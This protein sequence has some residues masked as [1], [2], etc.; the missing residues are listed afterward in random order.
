LGC[1]GQ[2]SDT[3][4]QQDQQQQQHQQQQQQ[5]EEE[6][7]GDTLAAALSAQELLNLLQHVIQGEQCADAQLSEAF[8]A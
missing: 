5:E 4:P 3:P 2:P 1:T 8:T 6:E 7:E